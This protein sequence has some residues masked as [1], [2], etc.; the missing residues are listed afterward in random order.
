MQSDVKIE[1][2][3]ISAETICEMVETAMK[4]ACVAK[5][6]PT[7]FVSLNEIEALSRELKL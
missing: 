7:Q 4:I 3:S 5:G 2:H 6:Q 1:Q